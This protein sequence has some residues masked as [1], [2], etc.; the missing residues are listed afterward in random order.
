M[1]KADRNIAL[2]VARRYGKGAKIHKSGGG[3]LSSIFDTFYGLISGKRPD[4]ASQQVA[5][6]GGGGGALGSVG[7]FMNMG[8]PGGPPAGGLMDVMK[9]KGMPVSGM[10]ALSGNQGQPQTVDTGKGVDK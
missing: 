2:N 9:A 5:G 4:S 10:D 8:Q 1:S 6:G 3:P 7:G